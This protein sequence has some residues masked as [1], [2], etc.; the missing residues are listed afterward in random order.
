MPSYRTARKVGY[1][2]Y[3][4][5]GAEPHDGDPFVGSCVT[6]GHAKSLA[7]FATAGLAAEKRLGALEAFS[8]R[9]DDDG[10]TLLVYQHA[11]GD[12]CVV[13]ELSCPTVA[14]VAAVLWPSTEDQQRPRSAT[15]PTAEAGNTASATSTTRATPGATAACAA[16]PH[17]T[18]TTAS[19][20][21]A[22]TST[23]PLRT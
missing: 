21:S 18:A 12:A 16:S 7:R 2:L 17:T 20:V 13:A 14:E 10:R 6:P 23:A 19:A 22:C 8:V 5:T 4:Q 3:F 1:T 15:S 11:D 9:E